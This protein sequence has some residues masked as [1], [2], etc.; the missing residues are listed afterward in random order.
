MKPR[1]LIFDCDGTLVD[2][3]PAHYLAWCEALEPSGLVF[4][5]Q[6]FYDLGGVSTRRIIELLAGEQGK[7][8]DI[9]TT[10]VARDEAFFRLGHAVK[11]ITPVVEIAARHRG[12]VPMAVATGGV[13]RQAQVG[14]RAIGALDWFD[15]IAS[16]DDVDHPKPAPDVFELAARRIDVEAQYC[17][18]YEDTD[19]GLEAARAAG[20]QVVDIRTLL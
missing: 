7:S 4:T 15:A 11:P 16:A 6:R 8:V 1:A 18:A 14:L 17:V 2:S 19:L 5:E 12:V 20:M 13:L 10:A 9:E 3:M